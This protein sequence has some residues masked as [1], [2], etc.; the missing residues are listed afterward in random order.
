MFVKIYIFSFVFILFGVKNG[1]CQLQPIDTTKTNKAAN[2]D[3]T[4]IPILIDSSALNPEDTLIHHYVP[5]GTKMKY[6]DVL[7]LIRRDQTPAL[8][9][10]RK[11]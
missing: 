10:P 8:P 2:I 1:F 4:I 5:M 9:T 11:P 3:G 6:E 7:I